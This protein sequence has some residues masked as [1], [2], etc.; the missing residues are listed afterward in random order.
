M[1]LLR[2]LQ[3][4]E[5]NLVRAHM[6]KNPGDYEFCS[7]REIKVKAELGT[8]LKNRIVRALKEFGFGDLNDAKIYTIYSEPLCF[9]EELKA[10]DF[11]ANPELKLIYQN[12]SSWSSG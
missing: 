4:V 8:I 12:S 7:F 9:I 2:C 5:L 3:Y 11:L 6:V 1:A 10:F